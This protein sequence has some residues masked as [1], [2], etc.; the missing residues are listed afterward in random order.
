[1]NSAI[2]AAC[3][4]KPALRLGLDDV[5]IINSAMETSSNQSHTDKVLNPLISSDV[6]KLISMHDRGTI[7]AFEVKDSSYKAILSLAKHLGSFAG[8]SRHNGLTP[9]LLAQAIKFVK[10]VPAEQV[11]LRFEVTDKKP[12]I[13]NFNPAHLCAYDAERSYG[14][15]YLQIARRL[16]IYGSTSSVMN[17]TDLG[18]F[19]ES[20]KRKCVVLY[21]GTQKNENIE[22]LDP[23]HAMALD[24][25]VT[26]LEQSEDVDKL[27]AKADTILLHPEIVELQQEAATLQVMLTEFRN[28]LD[29]DDGKEIAKRLL[30]LQTNLEELVDTA[31]PTEFMTRISELANSMLTD[32]MIKEIIEYYDLGTDVAAP[33]SVELETLQTAIDYIIEDPTLSAEEQGQKILALLQVGVPSLLEGGDITANQLTVFLENLQAALIGKEISLHVPLMEQPAMWKL[34]HS[35]KLAD[36]ILLLS[37]PEFI[38]GLSDPALRDHA[39]GHYEA[40][41]ILEAIE[42]LRTENGY[43]P[44]DIEKRLSTLIPSSVDGSQNTADAIASLLTKIGADPSVIAVMAQDSPEGIKIAEALGRISATLDLENTDPATLAL[45]IHEALASTSPEN[46]ALT[47]DIQQIISLSISSPSSIQNEALHVRETIKSTH[48]KTAAFETDDAQPQQ[49]AKVF[50]NP[51]SAELSSTLDRETTFTL[52]TSPNLLEIFSFQSPSEIVS[53]QNTIEHHLELF[54]QTTPTRSDPITLRS[55]DTDMTGPQNTPI[56]NIHTFSQHEKDS[57]NIIVKQVKEHP[58]VLDRL[59]PQNKAVVATI[60]AKSALESL[61][62]KMAFSLPLQ[63]EIK[64]ALQ[65]PNA[66]KLVE[67][68]N[69]VVNTL[70]SHRQPPDLATLASVTPHLNPTAHPA[71]H[72]NTPFTPRGTEIRGTQTGGNPDFSS[73]PIIPPRQ[74]ANTPITPVNDNPSPVPQKTT[75]LKQEFGKV[76]G[77]TGQLVCNCENEGSGLDGSKNDKFK[78]TVQNLKLGEETKLGNG[79]TIEVLEARTK[80]DG[81]TETIFAWKD[82]NTTVFEGTMDDI[83]QQIKKNAEEVKKNADRYERKFENEPA[84]TDTIIASLKEQI[85]ITLI[86]PGGNTDA[87]T[88][89]KTPFDDPDF[90]PDFGDDIHPITPLHQPSGFSPR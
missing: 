37:S 25:V 47:S 12:T 77:K 81:T 29:P 62:E 36:L 2:F 88:P 35:E 73:S 69:K 61:T 90:D 46:A 28:N 71:P 56:G 63:R 83:Q 76:C 67:V 51:Q 15:D 43:L 6:R 52:K 78:T 58:S 5:D 38:K 18:T 53:S 57:L 17:H 34:E 87:P 8:I 4:G 49:L 44:L 19:L 31:I 41:Q 20:G 33:S 26:G 13:P 54:T 14:T 75:P 24:L 65:S 27:L 10:S 48:N 72:A 66:G 42:S 7:Q 85:N 39:Q 74:E 23:A 16:T 21:L 86:E 30:E 89:S 82:R 64:E 60:V 3:A 68:I 50:T 9:E 40:L 59:T 79:T 1:M 32:E 11:F 84:P 70:P 55:R 45:K 80:K 22:F